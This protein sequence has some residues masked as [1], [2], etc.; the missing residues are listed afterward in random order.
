MNIESRK[1]LNYA[2]VFESYNIKW[3]LKKI[4]E[5][6][7]ELS[8]SHPLSTISNRHLNLDIIF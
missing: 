4:E 6:M 8:I 2:A 3:Q 1:I 7:F 5:V